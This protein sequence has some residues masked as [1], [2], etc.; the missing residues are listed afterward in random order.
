MR[1]KL[2]QRG[3]HSSL[4]KTLFFLPDLEDFCLQEKEK[5]RDQ[6][7]SPGLHEVQN[8]APTVHP[9]ARHN[10]GVLY[11]WFQK[12]QTIDDASEADIYTRYY[13]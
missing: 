12:L 8:N 5:K 1:I 3:T 9:A 2:L 4:R 13:T 7:T 10:L 6:V 11:P